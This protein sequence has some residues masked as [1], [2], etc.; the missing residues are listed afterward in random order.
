MGCFESFSGVIRPAESVL[1]IFRSSN[2][3][4]RG[5][6]ASQSAVLLFCSLSLVLTGRACSMSH[7]HTAFGRGGWPAGPHG[8]STE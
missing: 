1:E 3:Q 2:G 8:W 4:D 6:L 7:P 5:E